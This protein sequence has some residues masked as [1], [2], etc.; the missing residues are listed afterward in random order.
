MGALFSAARI[1]PFAV[2]AALATTPVLALPSV[3]LSPVL[4]HIGSTTTVSGSGFGAGEAVDIYFDIYDEMLVTTDG[5][6]AFG[7]HDI[8]IQ[9]PS[10]PGTHWITA[11]GRR[12]GDASQKSFVVSTTWSSHGF[13]ARGRRHNPWENVITNQN[14]QSLDLLWSTKTGDEVHSSPAYYN[15]TVYV[16]SSDKRLYAFKAKT[17]AQVWKKATGGL[18]GSSPAVSNGKVYVAS[19]DGK[20]YAF[21]AATG[22]P[23][24]TTANIGVS[25][26]SPAVSGGKLY[27]GLTDGTV[28]ALDATSGANVWSFPTGAAVDSSPAVVG[29]LMYV[30]S[31]DGTLYALDAGN[32]SLVWS[33][34]L[35][36]AVVSSPAVA[37]GT[38]YVGG[39][40]NGEFCALNATKLGGFCSN[41]VGGAIYSSPAVA[42]GLVYIGSDDHKLYALD[43][44]TLTVKWSYPTG[45]LVR[46]SPALADSPGYSGGGRGGVVVVGSDDSFLYA[47]D[48]DRYG[49]GSFLWR[50]Q[51]GGTVESSPTVAD[52]MVFVGSSDH[53]VYAFAL[54]GGN[55]VAYRREIKPPAFATLH[56]DFRL[57]PVH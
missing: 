24:W 51:T 15:G 2:Y 37:N 10:S 41:P 46:S 19:S 26:S 11:V 5:S 33:V 1:A 28:H 30:G 40:T 42:N 36:F 48:G 45:G 52:G 39:G 38:V 35:G 12:D 54:N 32:G 57:K 25:D 34:A 4:G 23:I 13:D 31:D 9:Y 44:N 16:G 3:T 56:P 50:A 43:A 49:A 29:G 21:D 6:G 8:N 18:I 47:L 7:K 53:K 55:N 14:A 20:V 22:A 27:I 17:G